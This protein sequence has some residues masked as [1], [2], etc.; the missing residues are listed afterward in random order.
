M[1]K[2]KQVTGLILVASP[3]IGLIAASIIRGSY[4]TLIGIGVALLI[5]AIMVIGIKLFTDDL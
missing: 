1:K 3:L 2:L 4:T 5:A